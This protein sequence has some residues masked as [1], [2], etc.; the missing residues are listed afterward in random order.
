[1]ARP[2]GNPDLVKYQ[3]KKG[4]SARKVGDPYY[5]MKPQTLMKNAVKKAISETMMRIAAKVIDED[6][7]TFADKVCEKVARLSLKEDKKGRDYAMLKLFMEY[8]QEKPIAKQEV[9]GANGEPLNALPMIK[10][11]G[12]TLDINVGQPIVKEADGDTI[13]S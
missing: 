10:V 12:Q 2:G 13:N 4:E 3:W 5:P 7:S 8:T 9:T 11:E 6:G 1:M